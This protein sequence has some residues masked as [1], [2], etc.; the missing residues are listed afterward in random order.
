MAN[1]N[2]NS[3]TWAGNIT[4][5]PR[6]NEEYNILNFSLA[7]NNP[8]KDKD[9]EWQNDPLFIDVVVTR[10]QA[11]WAKD[12]IKAKD[13]VYVVGSLKNNSYKNKDGIDCK[14]IRVNAQS[15]KLVASFSDKVDKSENT[16]AE[17]RKSSGKNEKQ[18]QKSSPPKS[19]QGI[20]AGEDDIPF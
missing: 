15:V 19:N 4:S 16:D 9:G 8:Y 5:E 2:V 6:Y 17:P 10:E 14:T 18:G 7:C 11:E 1:L 13:N 12:K 3:G 20:S